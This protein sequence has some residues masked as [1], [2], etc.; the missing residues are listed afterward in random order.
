MDSNAPR[1]NWLD[2]FRG[3]MI[4]LVVLNHESLA[5]PHVNDI[6]TVSRMP[7]FFFISGFL[8][9]DRY[10]E[11]KSFFTKR[12][13]QLIIPYFIFYFM[14]YLLWL[15][16]FGGLGQDKISPIISMLNGCVNNASGTAN[17]TAGPLWFITTLFVAEIY[18]FYIKKYFKSTPKILIAL[19]ISAILGY[20]FSQVAEF[21]LPWNM[22]IGFTA[23][24]FYGLGYIVKKEKI[25]HKLFSKNYVLDFL[26]FIFFLILSGSLSLYSLPEY[27]LNNLGKNI[28]A[29]Y[30]GAISGTLALIYLAKMINQNK[31]IEL[32]GRNTYV[33][34]AFHLP[35]MYVLY[36]LT[37]KLFHLDSSIYLNSD[38]FGL[39]FLFLA[40]IILLFISFLI[41]KYTPFILKN[42]RD[43]DERSNDRKNTNE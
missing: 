6:F 40:L 8:L 24:V 26:L 19:S 38:L 32:I 10:T 39:I 9:S 17:I 3:I 12:F 23:V 33:I 2:T 30:I 15:I 21:R 16:I 41:N 13:R 34:L 42:K 43:C 4:I 36:S 5:H 7:A 29:T 37:H 31:V 27:T 35:V 20:M 22:D 28:F 14:N 18:M 1:I 11:I 25:I